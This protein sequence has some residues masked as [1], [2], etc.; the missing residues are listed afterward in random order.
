MTKRWTKEDLD[1]LEAKKQL[2]KAVEV[3]HPNRMVKPKQGSRLEEK[4]LSLWN[5]YK[6][7]PLQREVRFDATRKWRFDFATGTTAIEVEGACWSQG[8]HTR[9]SGFVKDA[10]KY[11]AATL[12]GWTVYRLPEPL[13]N[14]DTIQRIINHI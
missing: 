8:R 12:A 7:P 3:K 6:G 9:G 11:L 2:A 4:F 5:F 13:I 1:W 10:E 14:A